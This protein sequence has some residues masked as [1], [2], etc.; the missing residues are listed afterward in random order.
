MGL[1]AAPAQCGYLRPNQVTDYSQSAGA[2]SA[3]SNKPSG[4]HVRINR[5]LNLVIPIE[6]DDGS[7]VFVHTA[8]ISTDV[9]HAYYKPM[10]KALN[11]IYVD[12]T[13]LMAAR[14]AHL[15]LRAAAVELGVWDGPAGV[16]R[17]LMAN[18]HQLTNVLAPA[19]SGGW[20]MIPFDEAKATAILSA[21]EA[22]EVEGAIVFFTLGSSLHRQA[23]AEKLMSGASRLWG[24]RIESL[25][26]TEFIRSL[27][28]S[29]AAASTG[30]T[31][32]A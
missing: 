15:A 6:R 10:A 19:K 29:T 17:G 22:D 21:N 5:S 12:G 7:R 2:I 25:N 32:K 16:E 11:G 4:G 8:S 20:E 24:A 9:F 28:T 23:E 27:A 1:G 3:T 31:A 18:I 14:I 13:G 30:A 26:C